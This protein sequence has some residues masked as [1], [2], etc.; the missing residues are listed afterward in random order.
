MQGSDENG[1]LDRFALKTE[2]LRGRAVHLS[3]PIGC[4]G[5]YEAAHSV[6]LLVKANQKEILDL[7]GALTSKVVLTT[8][9]QLGPYKKT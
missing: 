8:N 6:A 2:T 4:S 9:T 5:V 7:I 1:S 3:I